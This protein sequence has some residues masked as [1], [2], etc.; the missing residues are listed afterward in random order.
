M[1]YVEGIGQMTTW[2]VNVKFEDF[3][4]RVTHASW[5]IAVQDWLGKAISGGY[6]VLFRPHT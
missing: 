3:S 6:C 2:S 4:I 1:C 5:S